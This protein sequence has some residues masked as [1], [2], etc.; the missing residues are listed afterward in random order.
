MK[1]RHGFKDDTQVTAE[2][3]RELVNEY[4]HHFKKKTG[5]DFPE[6]PKEQLW[7]AIGAVFESWMA[8]KAVTYRRVEKNHWTARHGRE[9]RANGVRQYRREIPE[10]AFASRAI[11][12]PARR[13]STAI[14]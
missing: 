7:G 11:P 2:G 3:W 8:E 14:S 13:L 5:K 4:K 10:P 9:R 12:P 1:T 6:D